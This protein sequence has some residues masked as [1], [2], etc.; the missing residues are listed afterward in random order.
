MDL[1][2][3]CVMRMEP[4]PAYDLTLAGS[5]ICG[6]YVRLTLRVATG[7]AYDPVWYAE[8]QAPLRVGG[9]WELGS[10]GA[11]REVVVSNAGSA[12]VRF[13][14]LEWTANPLE[15]AVDRMLHNGYQGSSYA[16]I[17]PIPDTLAEEHGTVPHDGDHEDSQ[18]EIPGVS[19]WCTAVGNQ[20][21]NGLVVGADGATVLKTYV[22]VDGNRL[23]VVMGV[24][25]EAIVLEPG[26]SRSLDGLFVT[27]GDAV[28][29]LD[30]Y[31]ARVAS[32]HQPAV[33]RRPPM[34]GWGSWNLYYLYVKA[35]RIREEMAWARDHL[36]PLGLTDFLLDDGYM[37]Y[38][39]RWEAASRFG[40]D[41]PALAAEQTAMGLVPTI[42]VAP[43]YMDSSDPSV[44]EHP[45]W[46][47]RTADG[48]LR[49][50][51][52]F[53]R[54]NYA[55]LDPSHPQA[56]AFIVTQLEAL[57]SAGYRNF[58]L[59]FLYA[60]AI[61]G[62][63]QQPLTALESY[64]LF[65]Q[66][67]RAALPDAHLLAGGA[68]L[69]PSVGWLDSMRTGSDIGFFEGPYQTPH[70]GFYAAEAR[71]TI[72]RSFTDAWW[73]IDPDVILL[74]GDDIDDVDAWSS[75][76]AGA[77]A[78]GNY[79]LGD[80]RQAGDL[81]LAMALDPEILVL[82]DG[83]AARARDPMQEADSRLTP[84]PVQDPT[85]ENPRPPHLWEKRSADGRR[86]WLAVFAWRADPYRA[87]IDFRRGAVE[88]IPPASAAAAST[89]QSVEGRRIVEVPRHAVRLFR[90]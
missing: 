61:E 36:A 35:P 89:T 34:G 32:L 47:L 82:R 69:L 22:G 58:K 52:Q 27:L 2:S 25:G 49:I 65:M 80:G 43:M 45:D 8:A 90:W 42:W 30:A 68:P 40:A 57:W 75:V 79:L 28:S 33:A 31:A 26:E 67:I 84:I 15:L 4:D 72:V 11:T 86:H 55:T 85:G 24:T 64:H 23:R 12:P 73:A 39:G 66:T 21:G 70:Y 51:K 87:D 59:D 13:V 38:W 20:D 10:A 76:V 88:I 6:G 37:P 29:G 17:E 48:Q 62:V 81:R 74:R 56:R 78:G 53:G 83:I 63:R 71:Q 19:W 60:G 54:G 3:Q 7:D 50:Y 41:L 77:L 14:G 18:A 46:F 9:Q 44:G 1:A 5:G 16:G